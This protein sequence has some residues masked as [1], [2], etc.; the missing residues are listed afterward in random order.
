MVKSCDDGRLMLGFNSAAMEKDTVACQ[1]RGENLQ[2]A[3]IHFKMLDSP[4]EGS[5]GR[6]L[7]GFAWLLVPVAGL[8]GLIL[9]RKKEKSF[10]S[11]VNDD[12]GIP[13]GDFRFYPQ[14]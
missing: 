9:L 4:T 5:P 14:E 3:T 6:S 7:A 10:H 8:S 12:G 13:M 2:C 11:V 1:N